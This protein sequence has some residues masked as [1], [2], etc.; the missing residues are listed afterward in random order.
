MKRGMKKENREFSLVRELTRRLR[1]GRILGQEH[2]LP[3]QRRHGT[4]KPRVC[5]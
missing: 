2:A 5:E 3:K 4:H 1:L